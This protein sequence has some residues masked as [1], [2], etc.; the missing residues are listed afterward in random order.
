MQS[1]IGPIMED[2]TLSEEAPGK[3]GGV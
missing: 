3:P 1:C 2:V